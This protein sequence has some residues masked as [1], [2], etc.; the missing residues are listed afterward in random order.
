MTLLTFDLARDR[1]RSKYHWT[2][3]FF[4]A[5]TWS[6]IRTRIPAW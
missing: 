5:C 1:K 3:M 2:Y 4:I 6:R